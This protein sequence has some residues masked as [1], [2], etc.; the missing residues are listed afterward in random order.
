MMVRLALVAVALLVGTTSPAAARQCQTSGT[1]WRLID[2]RKCWFD[3]TRFMPKH[4]LHWAEPVRRSSSKRERRLARRSVRAE[5]PMPVETP[6]ESK[7][8]PTPVKPEPMVDLSVALAA[9]A[10]QLH[11][12]LLAPK[13][14]RT[15]PINP[16]E[17]ATTPALA[18]EIP[19]PQPRP[20][21]IDPPPPLLRPWFS[22]LL[23]ILLLG[24]AATEG[25]YD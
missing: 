25:K 5:M 22:L 15:V 3:G 11:D 1:S 13:P 23:V 16:I 20:R 19:M 6:V 10:Q 24:N 12:G 7:P 14:V 4:K 17:L 8:E 9:R 18:D 21:N 2:G